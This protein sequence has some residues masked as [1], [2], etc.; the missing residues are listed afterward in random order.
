[1]PADCKA[2]GLDEVQQDNS[3]LSRDICLEHFFHRGTLL[4]FL[5]LDFA[6]EIQLAPLLLYGQGNR[7]S[8]PDG[9]IL[10]RQAKQ[11]PSACSDAASSAARASH[12]LGNQGGRSSRED[13][14][15]GRCL[16]NAGASLARWRRHVQKLPEL[17][18]VWAA[19]T[20]FH[21]GSHVT[22]PLRGWP[23]GRVANCL[24][25]LADQLEGA[26][27]RRFNLGARAC[28]APCARPH[29]ALRCVHQPPRFDASQPS[30][31]LA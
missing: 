2:P 29:C 30:G 24:H 18:T 13:A 7:L 31:L 6:E 19:A 16:N 27:A 5:W 15:R 26:R 23:F 14:S 1:M 21:S 3:T 8:T 10:R 12:S 9:I 28:W 22:A 4:S 17:Q 11:Q 20:P 25:V